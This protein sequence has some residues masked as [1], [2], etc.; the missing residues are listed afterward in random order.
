MLDSPRPRPPEAFL[1]DASL[2]SLGSFLFDVWQVSC[3]GL[4]LH[5]ILWLAEGVMERP[6]W[7]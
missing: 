6:W 4:V 2:N 3:P 1:G 7:R 5:D